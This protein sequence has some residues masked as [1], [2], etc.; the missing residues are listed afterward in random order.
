LRKLLKKLFSIWS[1]DLLVELSE[2][3]LVV[4]VLGTPQKVEVEPYIAIKKDGK[5]KVIEKVGREAKDWTSHEIEVSNP[6]SHARLLVGNFEKA[7]KVLQYA[8]QQTMKNKWLKP[9][10]RVVMHQLEKNE[11][12]LTDIEQKVLRELALGAGAR[13]VKVHL[14]KRLNAEIT[15]FDSITG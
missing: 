9:S 11:G 15:K 7:E 10:P 13:M 5:H 1:N 8:V 2:S 6:F 3:L 4:S 12:G 14:G